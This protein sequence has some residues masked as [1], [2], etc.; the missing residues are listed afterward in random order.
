MN[1]AAVDFEGYYDDECSI[2]TLGTDGYLLHPKWYGYL[3]SIATS[4]GLEYVGDIGTA[5]WDQINGDEWEWVAHNASFD[6]RMFYYLRKWGKVPSVSPRLW[7]CS[8]DLCAYNSSPRALAKAV[9]YIYKEKVSKD[10]RTLMKGRHWSEVSDENKDKVRA[11]GVADAKWCLRLWTDLSPNWPEKERALSRMSRRQG[12]DG[13][14]VDVPAL[15]KDI[16]LLSTLKFEAQRLI[17]WHGTTDATLAYESLVKE[18]QKNGIEAPAS[19]AMTSD[20][21]AEWEDKYGVQFPWIDAMRM[22]R[23]ANA[24]LK[25]CETMYSR[26]RPEDGRM[27]Y[28]NKYFGAHTGRWGDGSEESGN[29]KDTGFNTRNLPRKEMFGEEFFLGK[30]N[31]VETPDGKLEWDGTRGTGEGARFANIWVPGESKGINLRNRIVPASGYHFL[32]PDLS[33]IEPRCLWRAVGDYDS[34]AYCRQGMS[35]YEAHARSSMGYTGGPMKQAMKESLEIA[36]QYQLAKAR[37]LALGYGAGWIKFIQMAPIYVDKV[38]CERI[39]AAPVSAEDIERFEEYL[40]WCKIADW[41]AR[42]KNADEKMKVT[43][44]N[45][46]KIVTDFRTANPKI[47]NK[48]K[49]RAPLGIWAKLDNAVRSAVGDDFEMVLPSGRKMVYRK[50]ALEEGQIKGTV[51]K[52][53]KP[54]RIKLY[55]GLLTE[56]Y[57]QAT[58][59][60][61]FCECL[62]RLEDAGHRVVMSVHDE[63]VVEAPTWVKAEEVQHIMAQPPSFWPDLPVASECEAS[64]HY[65][66]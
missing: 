35:P 18:C 54:C 3:V 21:C 31:L 36:G 34:L 46:W 40:G 57:I 44:I 19:T 47:A 56:N 30:K 22:V 13:L 2:R 39:F 11:A 53:G 59:R 6:E 50:I 33:Q 9:S 52:Y 65:T 14:A 43:Y 37:V 64:F 27:P 38:T 28:Q 25:K 1:Y 8:A 61:V 12:W 60:D 41:N 32:P 15:E 5:P 29:K 66:K 45:S 26:V 10:Y 58:A 55:G 42:Y 63:A 23:R 17:P 4:T 62:L 7:H 48:N 20:D 16:E 24:L 51:M 49:R